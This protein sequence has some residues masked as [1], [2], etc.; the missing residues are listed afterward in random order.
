MIHFRVLIY[1]VLDLLFL[2]SSASQGKFAMIPQFLVELPTKC[3]LAPD[4]RASFKQSASSIAVI[5][6]QVYSV[7]SLPWDGSFKVLEMAGTTVR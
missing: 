6:S 7:S 5:G 4:P 1:P 3:I 2:G